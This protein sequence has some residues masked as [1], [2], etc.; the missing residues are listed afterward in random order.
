MTSRFKN[1][2]IPRIFKWEGTVFEYD[3]D[4]RGGATKFG[5]DQRS[6]LNTDIK[7]LTEEQATEIYW[8]EWV[9]YGCEHLSAPMDWVFF[10]AC[11]NCGNGRASTF[12]KECN[13]N[14]SKFLDAQEL[15]YRRL[16]EA[17]PSS[18][19]YLKG[20]LARTEDLRKVALA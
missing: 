16:A 4:D 1:K 13:L 18:R 15:F 10:N 3:P 5:I 9:K 19:K 20:W 8:R 7:N 6:H 12:L 2:I 17:R 14:P 11:V